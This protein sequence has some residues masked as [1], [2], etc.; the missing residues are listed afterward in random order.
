M[1]PIA[2]I[3]LA[4][5]VLATAGCGGSAGGDA[6]LAGAVGTVTGSYQVLDLSTG[7]VQARSSIGD[8]ATNPSYRSTHMVFKAVEAGATPV[9]SGGSDFG[10]QPDE[11]AGSAAP[12]RYYI[13]VF[14]TTQ[15][16]WTALGGSADWTTAPTTVVGT[17]ATDGEKPAFAVTYDSIATTLGAWNAGRSAT[18]ALPSDVQWE[19]ACRAGSGGL[20]AWGDARDDAT[21]ATQA[22]VWETNA[23]QLGPRR[24]GSRGANAFGLYDVHGNVWEWTSSQRIRGGSWRD[25]LPQARCANKL[26]LDTATAHPLVGLRLVLSL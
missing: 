17:T 12:A 16:Q 10:S 5:A 8:L 25:T 23:G 11:S 15:A 7:T 24:V 2:I 14:E 13:A 18:L 3:A 19:K 21:V 1:R 20:F 22:Q 4:I 26:A 9:G 6:G